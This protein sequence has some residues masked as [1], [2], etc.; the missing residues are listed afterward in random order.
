MGHVINHKISVYDTF[1]A[2]ENYIFPGDE[3]EIYI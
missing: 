1:I 3:R 2:A